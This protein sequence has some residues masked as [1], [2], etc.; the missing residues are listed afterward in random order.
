MTAVNHLT[1]FTKIIW[2]EGTR[3]WT[4]TSGVLAAILF[5]N[6]P[7]G[8]TLIDAFQGISPAWGIVPVALLVIIKLY[9]Q[10]LALEQQIEP[11]LDILYGDN[12][13][14]IETEWSD[15]L[16]GNLRL[17]KIGVKNIGLS[18]IENCSIRLDDI[19]DKNGKRVANVPTGLERLD[20]KGPFSLRPDEQKLAY[21][22]SLS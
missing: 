16:G 10:V 1:L 5:F 9:K 3:F 15:N 22:A 19:Y 17:V 13:F 20:G 7:L 4:I 8:D 18:F 11:N 12:S 21:V 2:A 6:K 14:Y